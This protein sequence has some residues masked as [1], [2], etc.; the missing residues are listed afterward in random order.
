M[1]ISLSQTG[2]SPKQNDRNGMREER[3]NEQWYPAGSQ[4][5]SANGERDYHQKDD[6]LNRSYAS[7]GGVNGGE[8]FGFFP[9]PE[10]G[11]GHRGGEGIQK[12]FQKP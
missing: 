10:D 12:A 2:V 5:L 1:V 8:V 11:G 6:G 7:A 4:T 9:G 3:Q